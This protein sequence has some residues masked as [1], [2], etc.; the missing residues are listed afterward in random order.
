MTRFSKN[1]DTMHFNRKQDLQILMMDR[2]SVIS[3]VEF[4]RLP[5]NVEQSLNLP[6]ESQPGYSRVIFRNVAGLCPLPDV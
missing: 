5:L 4:G 3:L 1:G 6:F 2:S